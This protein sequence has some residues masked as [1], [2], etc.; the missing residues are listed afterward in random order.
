MACGDSVRDDVRAFL[1]IFLRG[2]IQITCVIAWC[3]RL[4]FLYDRRGGNACYAM[5]EHALLMKQI[6]FGGGEKGECE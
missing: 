2:E 4:R 6:G 1:F 3:D 5:N